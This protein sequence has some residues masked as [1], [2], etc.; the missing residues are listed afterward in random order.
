M[1]NFTSNYTDYFPLGGYIVLI[2][3]NTITYDVPVYL[4]FI[5]LLL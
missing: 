2:V 5:Y 3:D 4:P 1:M